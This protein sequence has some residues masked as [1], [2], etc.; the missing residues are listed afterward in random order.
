MGYTR[1]AS[2]PQVVRVTSKG[3]TRCQLTC[4][5]QG[6]EG[7]IIISG[8]DGDRKI[9]PAPPLIPVCDDRGRGGGRACIVMCVCVSCACMKTTFA[10]PMRDQ[11]LS[12]KRHVT[13]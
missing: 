5:T 4:D 8:N 2:V 12:P 9:P 6:R 3:V 11:A 7:V 10:S 1:R 13:Y